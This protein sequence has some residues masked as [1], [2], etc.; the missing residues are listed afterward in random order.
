MKKII[1]GLL[2]LLWAAIG[3][4]ATEKIETIENEIKI[5][6]DRVSPSLVKVV[7]E[8]ARKYVATGIALERELVIT[9]SL[10]TRHPFERISVETIKGERIFAKVI[11]GDNRSGLAL[12]RLDKK[13]PPPLPQAGKAEVGNWVALIGLFY[14]RFP[15]I[16]QGIISSRSENELIL[17]APVAPGSAGGAVV[18]KK[19]E[20]LGIIRGSIGFSSAPDYTFKDNSAVIVVS[21]SKNESGNLCYAIPVEQVNRI[22]EKLKTSGK[23]IPGWLGVNFSSDSNQIQEV[24][25]DSPAAK[26]GINKG[27]RIE[28]IAGK[29]IARFRDI[30]AAFQF[31]QAGDKVKITV[32]R[33]GKPLRLDVELG[34]RQADASPP[35]PEDFP[36][37]PEPPQNPFPHL[38]EQL[39]EMPELPGLEMTLP[40]VR[41][42]VIEFGGARQLGVDVME[43]T[44]ELSQKFLIK[45]GYG[46]LISRVNESSAAKKA[47]LRTGDIMVRANG[48]AIRS[49]ADLRNILNA[50]KEK[51][52]VLLELYRDGQLKKFSVVPDKNEKLVWNLEQFSQKME[53]LK[54]SI[55]DEAKAIYKD[56]IRRLQKSRE[57][58]LLELQKQKELSLLKVSEESR[59][60]VLELKKLQA[61]KSKLGVEIRKEYKEQLKK[62][63]E[64][65]K[66]LQEKIKSE[67]EEK[68]A[69]PERRD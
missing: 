10:I 63:Q 14:D 5:V 48:S 57:K 41:N 15:A 20:L 11:G 26:A 49:T 51:E 59:K 43:M 32:S 64:E 56:E 33:A 17:N 69:E 22:V 53:N 12:L 35:F 39:A 54:E 45:E 36:E 66:I 23:I 16:T 8:N 68:T 34:E 29:P 19:G 6:L 2:L 4:K 52:A 40:R 61:G 37:A 1:L 65:I 13:G 50:L 38:A 21:G 3:V 30:A 44:D 60:L 27:D 42:Y 25:K 46:L 58:E 18:N 28:E 7:A 9:T 24:L 47:G 55:G 62:I 31:S 67:M